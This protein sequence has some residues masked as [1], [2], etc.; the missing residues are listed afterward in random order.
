[1][2]GEKSDFLV[3]MPSLIINLNLIYFDFCRSC[4][5]LYSLYFDLH[6]YFPILG[7]TEFCKSD[8]RE[9]LPVSRQDAADGGNYRL[10]VLWFT[11]QFDLPLFIC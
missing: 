10:L 3:G 11:P 5:C 7:V 6:L 2:F 4:I 1:M 9:G 8:K